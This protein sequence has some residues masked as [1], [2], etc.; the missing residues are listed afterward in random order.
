MQ[1]WAAVNPLATASALNTVVKEFFYRQ[2]AGLLISPVCL[3]AVGLNKMR[4]RKS[5][6]NAEH[7]LLKMD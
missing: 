5:N 7:I 2:T 4:E 1:Y 3:L 6:I